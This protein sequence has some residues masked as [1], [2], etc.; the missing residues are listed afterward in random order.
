MNS[1]MIFAVSI[2]TYFSTIG[3][4]FSIVWTLKKVTAYRM[5]SM[6]AGYDLQE[7]SSSGHQTDKALNFLL[8]EF[9]SQMLGFNLFA[10][11]L[12]W[13]PFRHGELWAW[14]LLWYYPLM[15]V[16]HYFAYAK[17]TL[18]SV[19]QIVYCILGS[20]ALIMTYP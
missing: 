3:F 8:T 4:I 1:T 15:F 11:F 14:A 10:L 16:W 20:L 5:L 7:V 6:A 12:I 13:I 2:F 18:F 17:G 9:T 19:V